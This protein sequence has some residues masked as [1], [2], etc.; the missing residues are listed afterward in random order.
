MGI[1][2]CE[3]RYCSVGRRVRSERGLT[4]WAMLGPFKLDALLAADQL[5]GLQFHKKFGKRGSRAAPP[6]WEAVAPCG[7][8][9]AVSRG[10]TRSHHVPSGLFVGH[11]QPT[12]CHICVSV[13]HAARLAQRS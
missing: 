9:G 7:V 12:G 10:S 6:S 2:L 11:I 1:A 13:L 3:T 8:W 4:P 5:S